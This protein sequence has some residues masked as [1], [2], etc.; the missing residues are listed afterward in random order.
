MKRLILLLYFILLNVLFAGAK[1]YVLLVSFDAFRWDYLNRGLTP[2]LDKVK[3]NGVS[4][5]SLRPSFPSKTF[6]NHLSIIT[7]MYP[8]HHGIIANNFE[9]P[10]KKSYYRMSDTISVRDA[11]WYSGEAFWETAERQGIT[12]ASYFWPGS[13]VLLNYRRPTY[14]QTYEH[15]RPYELR[16]NGVMNWLKLPSEKRPHFITLYFHETDSQ[17]HEFGPDSPE[18]TQSIKV[19]DNLAGQIFK[20]LEEIKMVDSVNVIFVSDHGMTEISKD[21]S[22]NIEKIVSSPNCKFVDSGPMMFVE[23]ETDKL[24]DVYNQLKKNENHFKVYLRNEVPAFYYYNDNPL[25]GS[26]V[27]IADLGWSLV[28]NRTGERMSKGNHGYD[29]NQLDMHGIFLA[30]G[31]NFKKNYHTGTLWNVDIYPLLCKLF[32]IYPKTNIDG[33]INRIEFILNQ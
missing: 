18:T 11:K 10:F 19:I 6:P 29:N 9:D 27:L 8:E 32:N 33:S 24:T 25:I 28:S 13:E 14:F 2:N 31:P 30:T 1:P 4:A 20:M 21:R 7:G 12:T 22:I 23:P 16:I 3:T 15:N 5:L 17:A 26:I